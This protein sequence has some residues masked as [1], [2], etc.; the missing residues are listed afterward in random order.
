MDNEKNNRIKKPFTNKI[1]DLI[2]IGITSFFVILTVWNLTNGF[3][4]LSSYL[5]RI[6]FALTS[7]MTFLSLLI[8]QMNGERFSRIFILVILIFPAV[9][10]ANQFT[11]DWIFYGVIRTD[12]LQNPFFFLKLFGGIILFYLSL[13]Y[14]RQRKEER[15]KDYG[16]LIIG[17]GIFIVAYVL[18]RTIESNFNADLNGYP[19]W[20]TIVKSV[21]G[22]TTLIIGT[23]IKKEKIK[24][25][26]GLIWTITL[27]FIFGLL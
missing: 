3:E 12:L 7:M 2:L 14:S 5:I 17:I 13:K 21:I 24:F 27:M 20:K 11:T 23:Q 9:L 22:I 6:A 15:T 16:V 25:K 1:I 19:I 8:S 18:T 4:Y 26:K 10:M